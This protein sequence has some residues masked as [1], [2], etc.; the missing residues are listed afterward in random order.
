M[1]IERVRLNYRSAN[2]RRPNRD[3]EMLHYQW[4]ADLGSVEAQRAVGQILT[5]GPQRNPEQALKYFRSGSS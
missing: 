2:L 3:Q 4:F 1:Q 5:H